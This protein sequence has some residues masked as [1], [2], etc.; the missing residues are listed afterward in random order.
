MFVQTAH[1]VLKYTDAHFYRKTGLSAIKFIVLNGLAFHGGSMRPSEIAEW[2][3]R[4]RHNVTTLVDRLKRDGLVKTNRN[5]RDR[6][7]MTVTLTDKGQQVLSEATPV[8]WEIVKEVMRSFSEADAV[9]LEKQLRVLRQNAHEGLGD[10]A[11]RS[12]PKPE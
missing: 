6:R 7:V 10:I 11:R 9:L 8:S 1:T 5:S 4:E 12:Q 3:Y 2:T